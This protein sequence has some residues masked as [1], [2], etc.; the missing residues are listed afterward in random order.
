MGAIIVY[1]GIIFGFGG[2]Y[3]GQREGLSQGCFSL[4]ASLVITRCITDCS[5]P[6]RAAS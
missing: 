1:L 5:V 6:R 4:G 3:A 2:S